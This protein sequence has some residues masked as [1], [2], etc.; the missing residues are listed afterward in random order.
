MNSLWTVAIALVPSGRRSGSGFIQISQV[1]LL[2]ILSLHLTQCIHSRF[3][4]FTEQGLQMSQIQL[5]HPMTY[6]RG[7]LKGLTLFV[8]SICHICKCPDGF[9]SINGSLFYCMCYTFKDEVQCS[10]QLLV[11]QKLGL[12]SSSQTLQSQSTQIFLTRGVRG[13]RVHDMPRRCHCRT[14]GRSLGDNS[15]WWP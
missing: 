6:Y 15:W 11:H 13:P 7:I 12:L 9:P 10:G 2:Q 4:I 8:R 3:L 14:H 5:M 1:S